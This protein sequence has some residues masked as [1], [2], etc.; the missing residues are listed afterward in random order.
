MRVIIFMA[1]MGISLNAQAYLGPGMGGGVIA[2][3]LGLIAA[4]FLGIFSVL[5]YPIKRAIKNKRASKEALSKEE[6]DNESQ[7]SKEN[8]DKSS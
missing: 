4:I 5:Y 8:G 3:L 6:L 7:G 1:V 2:A